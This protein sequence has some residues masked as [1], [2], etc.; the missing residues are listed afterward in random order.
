[1]PWPRGQCIA[2]LSGRVI[3]PPDRACQRSSS[4]NCRTTGKKFASRSSPDI[5]A[6][7]AVLEPQSCDVLTIRE[8]SNNRVPEGA[9]GVRLPGT[10][11]LNEPVSYP[12]AAEKHREI[13][14]ALTFEIPADLLAFDSRTF[15]SCGARCTGILLNRRSGNRI[16]IERRSCRMLMEYGGTRG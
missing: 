10:G 9:A 11:D 6:L 1:M 12:Y 14:T 2:A 3:G 16:W 5:W 8:A 13:P 15:D 7:C 4:T